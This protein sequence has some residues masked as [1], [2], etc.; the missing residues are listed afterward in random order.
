MTIRHLRIFIEVAETGKMSAAAKNC[1]I[2]QPTVSQAIR[3]LEEHYQTKL[4][5]RL[6]KRLY[7]TESGK[8]LLIY[9]KRVLSQFDVM[10]TNMESFH[11]SEHLRIGATITVG[12]CPLSSVLNDIQALYPYIRTYACVA[13]TSLI[14]RKLLNSELDVALVEGIISSPD[15]ISIPVVD[16]FLVLAMSTDHPLARKEKIHV[17]ELSQHDFIM[18]EKGSGTR[19][20][21]ENYLEKHNVACHIA[22]EATC[23]D[24]FKNA[25]RFNNCISAISVRL[26]EQEVKEGIIHVVRNTENDWNRSFFLVYHKDKFYSEPMRSLETIMHRFKRPEFLDHME[27]G[28]LYSNNAPG[29]RSETTP[30]LH[31][32][33]E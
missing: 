23:L 18:R 2:T 8:Q 14:E 29:K 33:V 3:E 6:S 12:A 25:I 10:E 15:L 16:D 24:A 27:T 31:G 30:C 28:Y 7:I 5:E 22:W 20:L 13:N 32:V 17:Q 21:F 9:A 4:F 26:V 11:Q 1:F 19:K